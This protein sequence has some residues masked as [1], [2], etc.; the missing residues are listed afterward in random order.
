[1]SL[2][3]C[4]QEPVRQPFYFEGLGVRLYSSQE[5]CYVIYNHPLLVMEGFVDKNLIRFIRE[6]LDMGFLALKLEKW[7]ESGED[8]D[9]LLTL[10]LHECDY[11]HAPEVS[12]F[13]QKLQ[14]YRKMTRLEFLKTKADYL[15]S[16]KQYGKAIAEYHKITESIKGKRVPDTFQAKIYNNLGAAYARMFMTDKACQAYQKSYNLVNKPEILKQI[17][18]LTKW[19]PD[20]AV[21]EQMRTRM[22]EELKKECESEQKRAEEKAGEA[23]SLVELEKLFQKDPIKRLKGAGDLVLKWKQE[24][25]NIMS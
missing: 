13:E 25:R 17:C 10:I 16:I 8:T 24:Y 11:Y 21:H 5:L 20:L 18:Y 15:F 7:Q 6:E 14:T 22:T 12:R 23:D 19:N 1:M 2:I 9:T 3:L 4:R